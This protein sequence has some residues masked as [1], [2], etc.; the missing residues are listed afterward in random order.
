LPGSRRKE[1]P[2]GVER[3]Y[4]NE[5][6]SAN[7][8]PE[9][10]LMERLSEAA[11]SVFEAYQQSPVLRMLVKLNPRLAVAEAGVLGAYAWFQSRRLE[12]FS[13][14][15]TTLGLTISEEDV[16]GRT[17]F[18]A[19]TS[20]AQHVLRES[21]DAKI[22][23]FAHLFGT[24]IRGGYATPVDCYEEHLLMLDEISER[25]FGLLLLLK[26]QEDKHPKR[27]NENR[28]QRTRHFW[29]DFAGDAEKELG[30]D[31]DKLQAMLGRLTR[32]GMYQ[33]ITGAF[34]DYLSNNFAEF[35]SALDLSPEIEARIFSPSA[36]TS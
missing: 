19:Y 7:D 14:E 31:R 34:W 21:R 5:V 27:E 18:D 23:L 9:D 2:W 29:I 3:G 12:V 10:G 13:E 24:F 35:L 17:F 8:L 11:R 15:F 1:G 32:T 16:A 22:R 6:R 26:R 28:L 36:R 20:T 4:D 33:E 30:V 25:E